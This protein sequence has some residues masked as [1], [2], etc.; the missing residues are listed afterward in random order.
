MHVLVW[1]QQ[2]HGTVSDCRGDVLCVYTSTHSGD[3]QITVNTEEVLG[4]ELYDHRGDP[5]ELDWAG[6][7]VNVATNPE[8]AAILSTLR[9][10]I[11]DYIQLK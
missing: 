10:K 3:P 5:G 7:H 1:L 2:G 11:L 4:I 9:A 6:E 8:N